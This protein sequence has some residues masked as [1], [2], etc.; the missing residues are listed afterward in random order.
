MPEVSAP[1]S[2]GNLGPGFDVVALALELR[3]SVRAEPAG[4]WSVEHVG[5]HL[6]PDGAE[7]VVLAVA[8]SVTDRPLTLTVNNDIPL[9]RGLGSSS[10]ACAAGVAAA[11]LAVTGSCDADAVFSFVAHREG[12]GD[13]AA[14]TVYGGLAAVGGDGAPF[15]LAIHPEWTVLVA[16]PDH[17]LATKHAR[18]VL[19]GTVD[20]P[21]IVRNLGR[22]ASLL[23]GLRTGDAAR[24]GGASGDE[25][26]ERPRATLHPDAGRLISAATGAGA[27]HAAWSG[28]G[29]SIIAFVAADRSADVESALAEALDGRGNV[30]RPAIATHGLIVGE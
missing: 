15:Q 21:A 11:Q 9:G 20:R 28:A 23:E 8:Q 18:Q 6:L 26:H 29:P 1:A 14:A 25:L 17:E 13:N 19:P 30:L 22:F 5:R 12:H 24:L 7:D 16:V 27:A 4:T 10:A 3:C 2:S